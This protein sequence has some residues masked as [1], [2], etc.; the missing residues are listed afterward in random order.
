[1]IFS[2]TVVVAFVHLCAAKSLSSRWD[3]IAEKHSW[4]EIPRGWQFVSPAPADYTFEMR[5]ALKQHNING[6]VANLMETSDPSHSKYVY[7][8]AFF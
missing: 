3:D 2:L 7:D 5:V 1:M 4:S 8:D 6:L